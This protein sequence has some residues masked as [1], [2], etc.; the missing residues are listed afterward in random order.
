MDCIYICYYGCLTVQVPPP[1]A[2]KPS[3]VSPKPER[4]TT[5][6]A[7]APKPRPKPRTVRKSPV[8]NPSR[9]CCTYLIVLSNPYI[10]GYFRGKIIFFCNSYLSELH[11]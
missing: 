6:D 7:P 3:G 1:T 11:E 2:E 10:A 4:R 5:M 8:E 9:F